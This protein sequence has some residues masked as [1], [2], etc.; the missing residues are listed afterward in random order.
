MH[1]TLRAGCFTI[2]A[3]AK[4]IEPLLKTTQ[5]LGR[6]SAAFKL[7]LGLCVFLV[8][9][10]GVIQVVHVHTDDAKIPAHECSIC[11]VAHAGI[12]VNTLPQPAPVFRQT[13]L[14]AQPTVKDELRRAALSLYIRPP[15]SV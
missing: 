1:P 4:K 9:L 14:A 11:S 3:N 12:L 2:Q 10:I 5:I 8:G 13:T 15:P 7:L 6:K